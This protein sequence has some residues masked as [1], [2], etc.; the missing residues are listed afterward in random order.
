MRKS[1]Q[2]V[3]EELRAQIEA[4]QDREQRWIME[5]KARHQCYGCVWVTWAHERQPVCMF[6][7]CVRGKI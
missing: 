6:G 3:R 2:K 1:R 4:E 7:R 5:A